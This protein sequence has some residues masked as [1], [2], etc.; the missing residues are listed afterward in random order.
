MPTETY[1]NT[2]FLDYVSRTCKDRGNR[3]A[4]R[5]YWS[6]T[7]RHQSYPVLGKLGA[8][9]DERK[10][11]LAVL[12]AE[13]P[14][15]RPG[16]GVGRAALALG[17]RSKEGEHPYDRQFQRL[18]AC[19]TL[20]DLGHQLHRLVKR[21]DRESIGL[22]YQKLHKKLNFWKNYSEGV[23]VEWAAE[24]WQAPLPENESTEASA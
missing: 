4:L 6:E 13:H 20:E 19:D 1:G 14:A 3:A 7:A 11:I 15:H 9:Q 23:K 5:R 24:F 12:Y 18:L 21:L 22:D 8:L 10:T 2:E 17:K 16:F